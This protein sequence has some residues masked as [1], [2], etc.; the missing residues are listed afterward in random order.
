MTAPIRSPRPR[1]ARLL[2]AAPAVVVLAFAGAVGLAACG[3]ENGGTSGAGTAESAVVVDTQVLA[4]LSEAR[5]LHHE[6]DV[7]E[8]Q[9]DYAGAVLAIDRLVR[10]EKPHPGDRVPEIEEVLADAHA[11][12]AEL[13]IRTHDTERA[14]REIE[15]GLRH[16]PDVSYFRG[17][18]F[19]VD[20]LV[21]EARGATFADAG[22]RDEAEK[23]RALAVKRFEEAVV[24]QD[25]VIARAL[26]PRDGGAA[27]DGT[28]GRGPQ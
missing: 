16:A 1:G 8:Q 6:A 5:A 10:A 18:L 15:N 11:R 12:L 23:A 26:G 20:G 19:E 28:N 17:H 25:E 14:S 13:L 2:L 3:R 24:T 7:K 22:K 27:K 4:Y 9:G 21:E